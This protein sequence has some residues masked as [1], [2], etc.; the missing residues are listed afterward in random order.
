MRERR[1]LVGRYL[2]T[3]VYL[4]AYTEASG[5]NLMVVDAVGGSVIQAQ[6]AVCTRREFNGREKRR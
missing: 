4:G 5:S 6:I 3:A 2:T 1:V